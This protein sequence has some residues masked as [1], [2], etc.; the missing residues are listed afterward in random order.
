MPSEERLAAV[1]EA[2]LRVGVRPSRHAA[3]KLLEEDLTREQVGTALLGPAEIL[4]DYPAYHKGPCCLVLCWLGDV[5]IHVVVSYPPKVTL[6]TVYRPD[7]TRWTRDFRR[8]LLR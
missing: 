1:R 4:E 5:A 7:P 2:I 8:R 3:Q 6:I